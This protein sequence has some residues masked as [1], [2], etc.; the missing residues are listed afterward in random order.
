MKKLIYSMLSVALLSMTLLS[1]CKK[2]DPVPPNTKYPQSDQSGSTETDDA[3]ADVNDF[4]S[5]KVGTGTANFRTSTTYNLPCGVISVDSVQIP[6]SSPA[7][8]TYTMHYGN[9]TKCGY[10]YKSGDVS[11]ALVANGNSF[12]SAGAKYYITFTNYK[13]EVQATSTNITLNGT[14]VV[15]NTTGHYIW[16][17]GVNNT[18]VSHEIRGRIT[19]TYDDGRTRIRNYFQQRDWTS[20]NSWAGLTLTISGDTTLN[21]RGSADVV[22]DTGTT[23][24]GNHAF[25]TVINTPLKWTNCN[26]SGWV[27]AG[28]Y[29]LKDGD[30]TMKVYVPNIALPANIQVQAGYNWDVNNLSGTPTRPQDCSSNAYKITSSIIGYTSTEYQLY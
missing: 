27:W 1:S 29:V 21:N 15:T 13:V 22:A 3:I 9:Q 7:T 17:T 16:E 28:P 5:N 6:G 12:A 20:S 14:L 2:P 30:A 11:F 23:Y 18:P 26:T 4:I 19:V 10:K 25:R 24:D 8:Y